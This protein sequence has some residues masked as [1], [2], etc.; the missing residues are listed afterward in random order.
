M[1]SGI[2]QRRPHYKQGP[3]FLQ[4]AIAFTTGMIITA[5]MA[6]IPAA[7]EISIPRSNHDSAVPAL[8]NAPSPSRHSDSPDASSPLESCVTEL[9]YTPVKALA[10]PC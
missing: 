6:L 3:S 7:D 1:S 10:L 4:M 5:A 2:L 9:V 8:P